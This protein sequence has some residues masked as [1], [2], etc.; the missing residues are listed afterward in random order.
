[1]LDFLADL[2]FFKPLVIQ[3]LSVLKILP[4]PF[5]LD[6]E[7]PDARPLIGDLRP[8]RVKLLACLLQCV[9][10]IAGGPGLRYLLPCRQ[11]DFEL[12]EPRVPLIDLGGPAPQ[13]RLLLGDPGAD[14]PLAGLRR[15][16][17][18]FAGV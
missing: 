2:V 5:H 16:N 11:R 13:I 4:H 10:D 14:I 1:M 18:T 9:A 6:A 7:F 15:D 8:L 17:V 3:L 12:G